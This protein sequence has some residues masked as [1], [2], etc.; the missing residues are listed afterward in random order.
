MQG[1][2][3]DVSWKTSLYCALHNF[4]HK[5]F[6][7]VHTCLDDFYVEVQKFQI[8]HIHLLLYSMRRSVDYYVF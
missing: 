3:V 5:I 6:L 1:S 4:I 2:N 8:S 7:D